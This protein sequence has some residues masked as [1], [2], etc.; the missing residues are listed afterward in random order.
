ME[1]QVVEAFATTEPKPRIPAHFYRKSLLGACGLIGFMLAMFVLPTAA[2]YYLLL[3]S[4]G[5]L[6]LRIVL[7]L[8]LFVLAGQG[9]HLMGWIGHDG[10]HFTWHKNRYVSALP[11]L[12]FSSMT[13]FFFESGMAMDHW[14][15]HRYANTE[16]D[17]D[18]RLLRHHKSFWR[19]FFKQRNRANLHYFLRA[20]NLAL[21]RPL[22]PELANITLPFSMPVFRALAIA[23]IV[24]VLGWLGVYVYIEMLFPGFLLIGVAAPLLIGGWLSGL[25]SFTEHAHTEVGD[26]FNTRSR[27]H[28]LFTLIEYGGNYHLE[29]HLYPSVPQWRLPSLHRWLRA[30]GYF[31]RLPDPS[32]IDPG[33]GVYRYTLGRYAYGSKSVT[34]SAA[35]G[36]APLGAIET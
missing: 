12:F 19:R 25:R 4:G 29:H 26:L 16:K 14:S 15:H 11:A 27:T 36:A 33:L 28:W 24:F 22:A 9:V 5:P 20:V 3:Q 2:S 23:N 13:L 8:P 34:A 10:F 1:P 35:P 7:S 32:V 18:L 17:P 6:W 30:A 31:D 21:G